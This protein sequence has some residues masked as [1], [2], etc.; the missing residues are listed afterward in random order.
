MGIKCGL[1]LG[2]PFKGVHTPRGAKVGKWL[3]I[4][5]MLYV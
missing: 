4:I 2:T 3:T 5:A 1:S